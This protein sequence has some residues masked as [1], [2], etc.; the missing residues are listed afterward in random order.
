MK[1]PIHRGKELLPLSVI[2]AATAGDAG[3]VERVL[4]YYGDYMNKLC[5]QT[6]YDEDGYP[7]VCVD[8]YMKRRLEI[9]LIQA[10]VKT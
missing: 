4:R 8:E 7:H 2:H 10:I 6:L 9:R 1:E 3:A 5:T